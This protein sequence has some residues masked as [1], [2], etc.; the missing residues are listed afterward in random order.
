MIKDV[1]NYPI[2]QLFD[3]EQNVVYLVPRYQREYSWNKSQWERLFDDILDNDTGYF[4]GSIICINQ[5][6]DA[7]AVQTL[8]LVDGQQRLTTLSIL[9]AAIYDAINAK[10]DDLDEDRKSDLLNLKRKLVLKKNGDCRVI[11]QIHNS[12]QQDYLALLG[13]CGVMDPVDRPSY[14]GNRKIFRAFNYFS[15]RLSGL[16]EEATDSIGALFDYLDR[17]TQACIVKI[18]VA[19]HAD[20]Y[21]L[22][23]SLNN[24]GMPLTA[25]D[26]LKNK[27]LAEL[28][29]ED[30]GKL[31]DYF[32]KWTNLLKH[33][34]DNYAIQERFFRH[35]YNAFKS[36][37]SSIVSVPLATRSNLIAVYEK[38]IND[39]PRG[40]LT[41]LTACAQTYGLFVL[42]REDDDFKSLEKSFQDLERIQG[43]PS[44]ILLLNLFEKRAELGLDL[45]IL[46]KIC[47]ALIS[48][49]VRRNLTDTPPT[50]DLTRLFMSIISS[51]G[52]A[53]GEDVYKVVKSEISKVSASDDNFLERLKGPIYDENSWV[54]RF[55]LCTLAEDKMTKETQVDLWRYEGKNLVWTIEHIFPQGKNIPDS[56]VSMMAGG[57]RAKASEIQEEYVHQLGNLTVTGFNSSLGNKSFLEKRDRQDKKG[58]PVGYKNGL[59]LNAELAVADSW[60]AEQIQERTNR[61]A[62][63][64]VSRFSLSD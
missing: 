26:L 7:L 18:E 14:A 8:D 3:I 2:S 40:C 39:T 21:T 36:E 28:E 12:N 24:R 45:V 56:W 63:E 58:R 32:N 42:Q 51:L 50:R 4:L 15:W 49:F 19:S 30:P 22:F 27:L 6:T 17:I 10:K 64:L 43:A 44:Y 61:L 52:S 11:P 59:L 33:L 60:S 13:Q 31:D 20:A 9:F 54:T 16:S 5:S 25:V 34:G 46:K 23:E 29:R 62:N 48:F 37:L 53:K 57:D 41:K 47:D 38:L 35:Y 55:L 1:K